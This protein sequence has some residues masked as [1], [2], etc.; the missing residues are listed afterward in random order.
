V[1]ISSRKKIR[2]ALSHQYLEET[3]FSSHLV[4]KCNSRQAQSF[5]PIAFPR[6]AGKEGLTSGTFCAQ[7][8][9][10][11]KRTFWS[12]KPNRQYR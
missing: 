6:Y 12:E 10:V 5:E 3:T 4:N 9:S 2:E 1:K 11:T 8:L 7:L